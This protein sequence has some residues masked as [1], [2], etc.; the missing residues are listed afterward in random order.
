MVRF[1]SSANIGNRLNGYASMAFVAEGLCSGMFLRSPAS[2]DSCDASI[3]PSVA[4]FN[5][6]SIASGA[7]MV[8]PSTLRS[9][10]IFATFLCCFADAK[11]LRSRALCAARTW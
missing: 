8:L 1:S 4:R 2:L 7:A 6:A 11:A 5:V 3:S 10:M 9:A